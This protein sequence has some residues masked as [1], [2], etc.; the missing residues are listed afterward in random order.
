MDNHQPIIHSTLNSAEKTLEELVYQGEQINNMTM[1][2]DL[3]ETKL[4][5]SERILTSIKSVFY[6]ISYKKEYVNSPIIGMNEMNDIDDIHDIDEIDINRLKTI[7]LIINSE[8]TKQ[9]EQLSIIDN[10]IMNNNEKLEKIKYLF[11]AI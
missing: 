3:I 2:L 4:S 11:D 8:L 1:D 6:R 7:N 10:K 9:N 5:I